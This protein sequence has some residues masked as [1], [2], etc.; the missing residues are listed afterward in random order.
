M[1]AVPL[2]A[3]CVPHAF[4]PHVLVLHTVVCAGQSVV[5][6]CIARTCPR[7]RRFGRRCRYT[8]SCSQRFF[9][10]HVPSLHVLVLQAVA[11]AVQSFGDVQPCSV[12]LR[13][14]LN[15]SAIVASGVVSGRRIGAIRI[16]LGKGAAI[17]AARFAGRD[18]AV[19]ES[20]R[21]DTASN[22]P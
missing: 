6:G 7:R 21:A 12:A 14:A 16:G 19:T 9:V 8:R 17:P 22:A 4:P 18:E 2:A 20:V 5:T 10:P 1:H 11:E 13:V 15:G 3:F